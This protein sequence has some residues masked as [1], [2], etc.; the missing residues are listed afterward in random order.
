MLIS[1][2]PVL[3]ASFYK[4]LNIAAVFKRTLAVMTVRNVLLKAGN[5][6]DLREKCTR[7]THTAL[8]N[9]PPISSNRGIGGADGKIQRYREMTFVSGEHLG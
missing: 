6:T 7:N 2:P 5:A 4:R 8:L 3:I 1:R 9:P